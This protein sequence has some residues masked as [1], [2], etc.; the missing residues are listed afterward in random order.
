MQKRVILFTIPKCNWCAKAKNFLKSSGIKFISVDL[1]KNH[2][3]RLECK[4]HKCLGAPVILIENR[5]ICGFDKEKIKQSLK[6]R[7]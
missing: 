6:G 1:S 5:W 2:R 7:R 3:A 4:K